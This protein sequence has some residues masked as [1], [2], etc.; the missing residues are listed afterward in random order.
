M[1]MNTETIIVMVTKV[2]DGLVY[3]ELDGKSVSITMRETLQGVKPGIKM[4]IEYDHAK[5]D[6][7]P[8]KSAM[9]VME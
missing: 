2:N 7:G 8:L 5:R 3:F 1:R 6:F 9:L 4:K